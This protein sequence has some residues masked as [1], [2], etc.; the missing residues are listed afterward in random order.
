M[1]IHLIL[2]GFMGAGKTTVGKALSSLMSRP[3]LDTDQLIE[4]Q[5]GMS[6]SRIFEVCGEEEFRR[7]ETETIRTI[8]DR[9]E[10]VVLSVGGGLPLREENRLLLRQAGQVVYLRVK[11]Q[12]V[13]TRLK[14]DTTRPLLQGGDVEEKVRNLLTLRGPVYEEG[15]HLIVDV[16]GKT[17]QQI[18]EEILCKKRLKI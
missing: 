5:A 13:L 18:G 11:P 17:P 10:A 3:L 12:T 9:K 2:T 16:D 4:A 1:G 8:L 14:G 6:V 7:L 15:A